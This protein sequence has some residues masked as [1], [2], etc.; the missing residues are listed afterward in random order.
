[1]IKLFR[2]FYVKIGLK[3]KILSLKKL[4]IYVRLAKSIIFKM[5]FLL[6]N[7]FK[8]INM[9]LANLPKAYIPNDVED[10]IYQKW[11][12]S[13]YF[14]PDNLPGDRQEPYFIPMPPPNVTG[15]LHLGHALENSIMDI[16][17]RYQRLLGKKAI[18]FPG[19]DHAAVATQAKVEKVLMTEKGIRN[20][21]EE[22][23]REKLLEI[24]REFAENSKSTILK[25]IRKMGTSCDWSRLAYT[26]DKERNNTVNEVFYRMY[27]DGL[28]FKGYRVVN[29]SVKGQSTCSDDELEYR[30]EKTV[31]YTFK[32][33]KDFP[34]AISTTRPETKLGD[35]A[36]A[37]NPNDE[38]YK[39]YIGKTITVDVN[40]K[41]PLEIKIISDDN[42]DPEY[43]TGALGVTPAHSMVDYDMFLNH[44]LKMIQVIGEDGKMTENAGTEYHGITIMQA[45]DKFVNWLE[46]N[47]LMIS[48]ED[49]V[50]KVST[51]DRFKDVV[52]VVPK[53]QWF[54]DVNKEIP[55]KGK[56]LKNLMREAVTTG[57]NGNKEKRINIVP[58]RFNNQYLHWIDNL[59]PWCISRQV[60]WGH[61]IPV[62][63]CKDCDHVACSKVGLEKCEKCNSS[64]IYQ[65]EDTLDTWFSSGTW[66]FSIL[67]WPNKTKDLEEFHPNTWIQMGYELLFFW[68]ARMILMTT[69]ALDDIPFYEVYIHG[70][71]RDKKGQKF[72]KSLG[73]GIDPLDVCKEY[74]TDALRLSLVAG[75][76]PGCDSRFYEEK[77]AGNRNYVNKF[78]NISRYILSSIDLS[79]TKEEVNYTLAD[80]WIITH[81]EFMKGMISDALDNSQ[82]SNAIELLRD[83]T[84]NKFADWYLEIAK[85]EGN[86]DY[87]LYYILEQ[88]LI[89]HHP[90][91]PFITEHIWSFLDKEDY[92]M[93]NNWPKY[94]NE[95]V[96]KYNDETMLFDK[97]M[98]VVSIIRSLRAQYKI[99]PKT[100][101][102]VKVIAKENIDILVNNVNI[103]K[104]LARCEEIIISGENE[105][106][107][108]TN[109]IG[110]ILPNLEIYI[111]IDGI[112]NKEQEIKKIDNEITKLNSLID[113]LNKKLNNNEFVN[114]A[115]QEIV[116]KERE[117]LNSYQ[118]QVKKLENNKKMFN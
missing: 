42:V 105:R 37:V 47:D 68:L 78:W 83:F 117:K 110:Q 106:G 20:P 76:S 26:F 44:D 34:I 101:L 115:P 84:R 21:R 82:F 114:N 2:I 75:I 15:V 71:L 58:Q 63:Y 102:K 59:R 41:E 108:V 118:E 4:D 14:N 113:N 109:M 1:M 111:S 48:K 6:F 74:G 33:S 86:K 100:L 49:I 103:I 12:N 11:E 39:E 55:Q 56:T 104:K 9:D 45:R 35:T 30:E 61:R 67:G 77:V 95:I 85:I 38:R 23:G 92:L 13:G 53:E 93:V 36:V 32:Y 91:I 57:H 97:V 80:K 10:D 62:W 5:C 22:Y 73:N 8:I 89:I 87:I 72:S 3:I 98:D 51:S 18:I 107:D 40:A 28:I 88:L 17:V 25:Q 112:L 7:K 52:E 99:E 46:E 96:H 116:E 94:N 81:F 79:K 24:I 27:N 90:F 60:W 50:H 65:D 64:N 66:T 70:I 16:Q 69:Y 43:G 19:T 29:W 54:I 31:L